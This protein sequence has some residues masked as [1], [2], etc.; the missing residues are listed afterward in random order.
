MYL[1]SQELNHLSEKAKV[2]LDQLQD[3]VTGESD[4]AEESGYNMEQEGVKSL[5]GKISE[6]I[7]SLFSE[8]SLTKDQTEQTAGLLIVSDHISR[9]ADRCKE[10]YGYTKKAAESGLKLSSQAKV[11]LADCMDLNKNMF[12]QAM[13][14]VRNGDKDMATKLLD[15]RKTL[16]EMQKNCYRNHFDRV[17]NELCD[18]AFTTNYAAILY[19][20]DRMADNCVS[21]SEEANTRAAFIN[22]DKP[23][24]TSEKEGK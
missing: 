17:Q 14:A 16:H 3:I 12:G 19:S 11:E 10:I 24:T 9:M 1:I 13:L 7:T 22:L 4:A 21:I 2:M 20:M 5:Q 6:Y 8:G 15:E 23:E 18:P